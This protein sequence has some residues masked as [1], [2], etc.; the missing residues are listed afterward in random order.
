MILLMHFIFQIILLSIGFGVGYSLLL[1]ANKQEGGLNIVG[2]ILGW[3][4]IL[5]TLITSSFCSYY[6]IKMFKTGH[7]HFGC[8][9]HGTMQQQNQDEQ[10]ETQ[11]ELQEHKNIH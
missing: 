6:S 7:M 3:I 11:E 1:K 10:E 9:M 5:M 4:L 8:P 2:K